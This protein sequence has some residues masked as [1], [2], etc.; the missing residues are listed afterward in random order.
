ME[1][2]R[3]EIIPVLS[4]LAEIVPTTGRQSPKMNTVLS[5]RHLVPADSASGQ[6]TYTGAGL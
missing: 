6:R 2:T 3:T 1:Q 5:Q 4:S